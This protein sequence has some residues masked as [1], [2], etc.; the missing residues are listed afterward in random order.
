MV[1]LVIEV[2]L[3]LVAMLGVVAYVGPYIA[4]IE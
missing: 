2:S 3:I 4:I 1:H